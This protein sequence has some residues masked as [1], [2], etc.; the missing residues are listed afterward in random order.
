VKTKTLALALSAALAAGAHAAEPFNP[1]TWL[2][3]IAVT[4]QGQ[5]AL[6]VLQSGGALFVSRDK[7]TPVA[8]QA[9]VEGPRPDTVNAPPKAL[10]KASDGDAAVQDGVFVFIRD[11]LVETASYEDVMGAG[12]GGADASAKGASR[13]VSI[14]KFLDT[15]KLPRTGTL[16]SLAPRPGSAAAGMV[17]IVKSLQ[18]FPIADMTM[19][20]RGSRDGPILSAENQLPP[21]PPP[22]PLQNAQ[23]TC[24]SSAS[25]ST[26]CPGSTPTQEDGGG[27]F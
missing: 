20:V 19:P 22:N 5:T 6:Q 12:K 23:T 7:I 11:G 18:G 24:E 17:A 15:S 4:P 2:G 3:S 14:P 16:T 8:N 1:I 25:G 10:G 21:P 27:L 13:P 9:P 26:P